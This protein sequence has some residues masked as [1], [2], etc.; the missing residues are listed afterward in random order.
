MA[1]PL[2]KDL[3][4]MA[5]TAKKAEVRSVGIAGFLLGTAFGFGMGAAFFSSA[6]STFYFA[7]GAAVVGIAWWL[8]ARARKKK[9]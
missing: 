4:N 8:A 5:G 6:G 7:I 9:S 1:R 2:P 3:E